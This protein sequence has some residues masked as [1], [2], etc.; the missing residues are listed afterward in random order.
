MIHFDCVTLFPQM[1]AALTESGITGRALKAIEQVA[2]RAA[3]DQSQRDNLQPLRGHRRAVNPDD[4]GNREQREQDED[5]PR[6][7]AKRHAEGNAVVVA[8]SEP[9]EIAKNLARLSRRKTGECELLAEE[10]RHHDDGRH[11]PEHFRFC[12]H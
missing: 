8:E 10:I 11:R 3:Q 5:R 6:G 1:F 2:D 12:H 4:A 7:V 9:Q